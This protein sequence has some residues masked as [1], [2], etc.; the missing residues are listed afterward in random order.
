MHFGK[1][2]GMLSLTMDLGSFNSMSYLGVTANMLTSSSPWTLATWTLAV[3]SVLDT[4]SDALVDEIEDIL[5]GYHIDV[6]RIASITTDNGS[7]MLK[8]VKKIIGK[9]PIVG[10]K[11]LAHCLNLILRSVFDDWDPLQKVVRNSITLRRGSWKKFLKQAQD[12][13]KK[14]HLQPLT[15]VE[16]RWNSWYDHACMFVV[17]T[18]RLAFLC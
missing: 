7:N 8:A 6:N 17:L 11:C 16:S 9:L 10:L 12:E 1:G 3:R 4:D 15:R 2:E 13:E 14:P 5:E 18:C